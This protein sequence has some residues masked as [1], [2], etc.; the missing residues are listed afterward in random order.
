MGAPDTGVVFVNHDSAAMIVPRASAL[1]ASGYAVVVVDNSGEF[2]R[3]GS[4]PVIDPGENVGFGVGCNLGTAALPPE[5][6]VVCLHNPDVDAA[7]ETIRA[8]AERTRGRVAA[9]APA[10]VTSTGVR[11]YGYH[12]PSLV[13]EALVARRALGRGTPQMGSSSRRTGHSWG[14]RVGRRFGSAALLAVDRAA[15]EAVGGFDPAYFLYG[16]DLDLWHRLRRA[17]GGPTFAPDLAV[18][19]RRA[20]GSSL[21]SGSRE[22]LRWIGVELFAAKHRPSGW[23]PYRHVHRRLVGRVRAAPALVDLVDDGFRRGAAPDELL[24]DIRELLARRRAPLT[25]L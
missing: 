3:L 11:R 1:Q 21:D 22:V 9:L 14:A 5:V 4:L 18:H 2:P 24:G 25:S 13:R 6:E 20:T 23:V 7:P 10:L 17:G 12:E 8:L 15:F 16:E 19:H